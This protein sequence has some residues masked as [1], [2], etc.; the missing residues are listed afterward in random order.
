MGEYRGAPTHIAV[1]N[2]NLDISVSL[3]EYPREDSHVFAQDSW[4]GL[5]GAATN[6]AIAASKLG[7][8]SRLVAVT[9][10]DAVKLGLLDR[11]REEGVDTSLVRILPEESTGTVIVILVPSRSSRTII[12]IRG[13]NRLLSS[14]MIPSVPLERGVLHF[15]ST[16]PRLVAEALERRIAP[17]SF[18]TYDPGGEVYRSTRSD[19]LEVI[20]EIN[21]LFMNDKEAETFKK[22]L[23]FNE[24]TY[25]FNKSN[26]LEYIVIKHGVGGATLYARD[27]S[28]LEGE[29]PPVKRVVDV[30]GAGDAFD[31]AFNAWLLEGADIATALRA[32]IAAGTGKVGMKGSSSMPNREIILDKMKYVSIKRL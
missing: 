6:Y 26:K 28:A 22:I 15:A 1:G 16:R 27:S 4:I 10:G 23:N 3:R 32:A 13:A 2:L 24:I 19:L 18:V 12:T 25:L 9:G 8:E 7:H 17:A 29:P 30:T 31:A 5:G 20:N 14:D 11:L 21:I